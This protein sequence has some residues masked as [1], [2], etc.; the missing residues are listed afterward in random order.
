MADSSHHAII[1]AEVIN[2]GT[3][4]TYR[5][6]GCSFWAH[7]IALTIFDPNF[8]TVYLCNHRNRALCPDYS[9]AFEVGELLNGIALFDGT[10]FDSTG[11][12]SQAESG[13]YTIAIRFETW[14]NEGDSKHEVLERQASIRWKSD[15]RRQEKNTLR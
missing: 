5:N 14:R 11:V 1:N 6:E 10:I 4:T 13:I 8:R 15:W 12:A 7:G 9:T 2:R 3:K